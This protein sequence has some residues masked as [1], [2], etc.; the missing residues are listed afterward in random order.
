MGYK[1][2][3]AVSL[4]KHKSY[5][6]PIFLRACVILIVMVLFFALSPIRDRISNLLVPHNIVEATNAFSQMID[7]I[8]EGQPMRDAVTSFYLEM[9]EDV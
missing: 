4:N 5:N 9:L 1:I 8:Q 2:R 3:Y 6:R 7:N